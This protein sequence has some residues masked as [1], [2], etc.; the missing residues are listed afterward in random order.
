METHFRTKL[1]EVMKKPPILCRMDGFCTV[2][3]YLGY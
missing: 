2:V 3:Q 1:H